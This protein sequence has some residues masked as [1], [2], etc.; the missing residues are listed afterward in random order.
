MSKE[1]TWKPIAG[2]DY[3]DASSRSACARIIM[4]NG[5]NK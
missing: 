2:Y 3:Y 4:Y 1:E 5:G